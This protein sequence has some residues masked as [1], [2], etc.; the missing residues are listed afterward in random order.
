MKEVE[1]ELHY[2]ACWGKKTVWGTEQKNLVNGAYK[3]YGAPIIQL[4]FQ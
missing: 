1:G 3:R 4:S 2:W